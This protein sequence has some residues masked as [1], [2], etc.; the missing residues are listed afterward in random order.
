MTWR[1]TAHSANSVLR[2][3]NT[4]RGEPRTTTRAGP[5]VHAFV[6]AQTSSGR[7][8]GAEKHRGLESAPRWCARGA[9]GRGG[10]VGQASHRGEAVI[11]EHGD[12]ARARG[13]GVRGCGG[14]SHT[15]WR[16]SR[17]V[18]AAWCPGGREPPRVRTRGALPAPLLCISMGRRGT[19]GGALRVGAG[20]RRVPAYSRHDCPPLHAPTAR[21]SNTTPGLHPLCGEMR[22]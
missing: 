3:P 9:S 12:R 1:A 21:A 15:P 17:V 16:N 18:C 20:P 19:L 4:T 13:G 14:G 11:Q 2:H 6:A 5:R 22:G 7:C 10:V 8:G